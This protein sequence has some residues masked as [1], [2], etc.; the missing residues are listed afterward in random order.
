TDSATRSEMTCLKSIATKA[1]RSPF[2]KL[3][4]SACGERSRT[5][6]FVSSWQIVSTFVVAMMLAGPVRAQLGPPKAEVAAIVDTTAAKPGSD[7]HA[8]LQV[9]LPEGYHTNSNQ[10]RDPNLIPISVTFDPPPDGITFTEVVFPPATDLAQ[11]GADQPLR[12]FSGDFTIGVALS[13][14]ASAPN[15]P[16][17]LPATLRYQACDEVACY[18]PTRVPVTWD[19]SVANATGPKQHGDI[20]SRIAFGTGEPAKVAEKP[21]AVPVLPTAREMLP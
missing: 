7:V 13:V 2:D 11:R 16:V 12:V 10:P 4:A 8:A 5:V 20:F 14:A 21:S 1:R 19:L 9:H 15:G 6:F 18:A 17:K 3:R